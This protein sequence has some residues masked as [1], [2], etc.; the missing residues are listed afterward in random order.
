MEPARE[1]RTSRMLVL[2][3]GL[4]LVLIGLGIV[5]YWR[6]AAE[7][8]LAPRWW[9]W[10]LLAGIFFSVVGLETRRRK[11]RAHEAL[12]E[13]IRDEAGEPRP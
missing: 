9:H 5:L 4:I 13:A 6:P 7:G 3:V 8:M 1:R 11:R 2:E 12:H 10:V